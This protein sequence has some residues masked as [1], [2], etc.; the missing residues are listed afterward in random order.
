MYFTL[1]C[2]R[3][4]EFPIFYEIIQWDTFGSGCSVVKASA[5]KGIN[6][7]ESFEFGFGEDADFGMQLRNIGVDVLYLPEP[8]ILHLK[9]P[10]GGFRTKFAHPWENELILPK[11]SPTIMY[12]RKK[13]HTDKQLKGYKTL[14]FIKYY[15]EQNIKNPFRYI[16]Q[17][18][19]QWEVSKYWANKL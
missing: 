9:A 1:T 16:F 8:R 6:F 4:N 5:L 3:K 15:F 14:L 19:K 13:Y 7:D 18:N 12:F 2:Y 17:M 10:M 11:P